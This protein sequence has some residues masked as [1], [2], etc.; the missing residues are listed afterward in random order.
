M[1]RRFRRQPISFVMDDLGVR[2]LRRGQVLE[3]VRWDDLAEVQIVTTPRG[4]GHD[5]VFWLLGG[6]DG[7]G[8]CV[9]SEH[10]PPGFVDRL[11]RLPDFDDRAVIEAMG[12]TGG[13]QFHCW[14][15]QPRS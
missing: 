1:L 8:V 15:A 3:E 12:S 5:D 11:Q 14:P 10:I 9:P 13:G 6:R 4:P 2:R 7:R